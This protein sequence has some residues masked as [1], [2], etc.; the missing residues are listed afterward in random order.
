M[1]LLGQAKREGVLDKRIPNLEEVVQ[2]IDIVV[3]NNISSFK[4][5]LKDSD[6]MSKN[7]ENLILAYVLESSDKSS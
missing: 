7:I 4:V 6:Y 5:T 2:L 3:I 1:N